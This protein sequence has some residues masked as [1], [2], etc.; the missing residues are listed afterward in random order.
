MLRRELGDILKNGGDLKGLDLHGSYFVGFDFSNTD[1][2]NT[3]FRGCVLTNANFEG[4][5]FKKTNFQGAVLKGVKGLKKSTK[6]C[7]FSEKTQW[8]ISPVIDPNATKPIIIGDIDT[9]S[10]DVWA[11]EWRPHS[12]SG[13]E[14]ICFGGSDMGTLEGVSTFRTRRSLL[15]TKTGITHVEQG[16]SVSFRAGHRMEDLVAESF[17]DYMLHDGGAKTCHLIKDTNMYQHPRHRWLLADM[18]YLV[19]VDG[20]ICILECKTCALTRADE[21]ERLKNKELNSEYRMQTNCYMAIGELLGIK[22]LYLCDMWGMQPVLGEGMQI[23]RRTLNNE[24][25]KKEIDEMLSFVDSIYERL[26]NGEDIPDSEEDTITLAES[27]YY[28]KRDIDKNTGK[29][30]C[31]ELPK[32][33]GLEE[34]FGQVK[35]LEKRIDKYKEQVKELET[36]KM[37]LLEEPIKLLNGTRGGYIHCDDGTSWWIGREEGRLYE[38][39][40]EACIEIAPDVCLDFEEITVG[41]TAVRN[42][43]EKVKKGDMTIDEFEDFLENENRITFNESKFTKMYTAKGEYKE[44]FSSLGKAEKGMSKN[45]KV[46]ISFYEKEEK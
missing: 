36:K 12:P 8:K 27:G 34:I 6:G 7:L 46:Y 42:L 13:E 28:A 24:K 23:F 2:S 30:P 26:L 32:G 18:D 16:D 14:P 3:D 20:E 37:T 22:T 44:P 11:K 41:L 21:I 40:I 4:C 43:I 31:V 29:R 1:L 19:E 38:W 10:V 45:G 9:V 33:V 17:V 15:D 5:T 25:T 35:I 39:D